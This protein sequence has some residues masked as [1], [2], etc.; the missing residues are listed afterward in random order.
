MI[1]IHFI[2]LMFIILI[3][4]SNDTKEEYSSKNIF[5]STDSLRQKNIDSIDAKKNNDPDDKII[6]NIN[7]INDAVFEIKKINPKSFEDEVSKINDDMK[8]LFHS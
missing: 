6:K 2:Q 1:M 4:C 8:S 5:I 3:G 7:S